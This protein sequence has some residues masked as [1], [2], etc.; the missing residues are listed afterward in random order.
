MVE[1]EYAAADNAEQ[2][3]PVNDGLRAALAEMAA[4]VSEKSAEKL[5]AACGNRRFAK[6]FSD[7]ELMRTAEYFIDNNL[8]VSAAAR[9]LYM[10]RNT[11]MYRLDK[12]N[13][14]IGLDI[15][16]FDAAVAFKILYSVYMRRKKEKDEEKQG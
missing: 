15:R 5:V 14:L 8:N 12:I 1:K 16:C 4:S 9:A 13:R 7:R 10:H 11:M 2:T 6:V 3:P